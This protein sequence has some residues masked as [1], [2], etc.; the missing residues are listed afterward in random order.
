MNKLGTGEKTGFF[1]NQSSI[2]DWSNTRKTQ[3]RFINKRVKI[4]Q[5]YLLPLFPKDPTECCGYVPYWLHFALKLHILYDCCPFFEQ[6]PESIYPGDQLIEVASK[7][8]HVRKFLG[9]TKAAIL[10]IGNRPKQ[11]NQ[12]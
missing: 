5:Q 2:F 7:S 8:C 12:I 6:Q 11:N 1:K 4:L 3:I 9:I 10:R